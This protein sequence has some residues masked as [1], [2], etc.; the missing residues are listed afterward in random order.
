MR[1]Y[2]KISLKISEDASS[3]PKNIRFAEEVEDTNVELLPKL[4]ERSDTFPV[5]SHSINMGTI[6]QGRY[7]FINPAA[8]IGVAFNG[9]APITLRA[10]KAFRAWVDFTS[11][12][13]TVSGSPSVV[14]LL[15]AGA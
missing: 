11:I 13:I 3:D 15:A 9:G 12:D 6:A 4:V 2:E 8:S 5:G 7:V 1:I 10:A 14:V